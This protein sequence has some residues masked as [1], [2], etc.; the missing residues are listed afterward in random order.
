MCL[1][2]DMQM[3]T[4]V[5]NWRGFSKKKRFKTLFQSHKIVRINEIIFIFH[6]LFCFLS[7]QLCL[8]ALLLCS[9][10]SIKSI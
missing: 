7:V 3:F 10:I 5:S 2:V 1:C 6:H 8:P 9:D 4:K